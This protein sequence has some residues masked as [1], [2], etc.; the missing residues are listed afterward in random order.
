[1][2]GRGEGGGCGRGGGGG[3]GGWGGGGTV[4]HPDPPT[5]RC[6]ATPTD[7]AVAGGGGGAV[8]GRGALPGGV[9]PTPLTRPSMP[10]GRCGDGGSLWSAAWEG[11]PATATTA[12]AAA[13]ARRAAGRWARGGLPA[14][15]GPSGRLAAG[16]RCQRCRPR[17]RCGG[18]AAAVRCA[19][20]GDARRRGAA[21]RRPPPNTASPSAPRPPAPH[22]VSPRGARRV[23]P[24]CASADAQAGGLRHAHERAD[25]APVGG[26]GREGGGTPT[27][28]SPFTTSRHLVAAGGTTP[29]TAC[30]TTTMEPPSPSSSHL[31]N[32][33]EVFSPPAPLCWASPSG[34]DTT[35]LAHT[36]MAAAAA[37]THP[38]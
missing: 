3:G 32:Q 16:R 26:L 34:R 9:G 30:G 27:A 23:P 10:V 19:S 15:A 14:A 33:A 8:G 29:P 2:G 25:A 36:A 28:A 1:V 20:E 21:K 24:A 18:D 7:A 6:P 5:R 38:I 35:H 31:C 37:R 4:G 12:H 13:V 22:V 17:R 11:A